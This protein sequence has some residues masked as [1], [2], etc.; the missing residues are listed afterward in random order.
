MFYSDTSA[1]QETMTD[2]YPKDTY[3]MDSSSIE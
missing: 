2:L 1:G 3:P